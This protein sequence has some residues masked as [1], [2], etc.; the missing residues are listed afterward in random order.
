MNECDKLYDYAVGGTE[1]YREATANIQKVGEF[2]SEG[3]NMVQ[4]LKLTANK[5]IGSYN[6]KLINFPNGTTYSKNENIIKVI[7][8]KE[9][10]IGDIKGTVNIL[11]A[12]VK[13]CPAF[14]G[15]SYNE[16]WQDYVTA[17]DP[18]ENTSTQTTISLTTNNASI[19]IAKEDAETKQL[20]PNTTL[21]IEKDN[22]IIKT[23]VTDE[24]GE[25]KVD[26]LYAGKYK[27]TEIKANDN[28]ILPENA[29]KEVTIKYGETAIVRFS[30]MHKKG[31]LK[32]LKVDKDDNKLT[33]GGVEFDLLDKKGNVVKHLVTDVNGIAELKEINTGNYILRETSTKKEYNLALDEDVTIKWNETF[34]LQVENEKKK[35]QIK[36]V[37]VDSDNNEVKLEGVE[38]Q[39]IDRNNHV[40]ET[41]KTGKN[42][43]AMTSYLPIGEYK[44]KETSLG[45]N[46]E[47]ILNEEVKTVIIEENKIGLIQFENEHKKGN[48]KIYKI[49]LDNESISIPNVEFE[50]TDQD[51]YKY[52]AK[53]GEDGTTYIEN[54]RSGIA[55]IREVKTNTIY[56]L[57]NEI[58]SVEIKWNET[59]K[60]TIKNE[61]LKGQIEVYKIDSEN[62]EIKLEGVEFE[63]YNSNNELVETIK[64][65]KN[66]YAKTQPIPIGEY[67]VKETKTDEMHILKG[68]TIKINVTTDAVSRLDIT[69][70][71][72][73]GKIKIVKTSEKDNFVNGD[74]AG[75]PI[76][77]VQ[78]E[79][80]NS[81]NEL[82][83]IITTNEKRNSSYK[84]AG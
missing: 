23:V 10:I 4:T 51:G 31:N 47:Y 19:K 26:N 28:Y 61:K 6:V 84:E 13:T 55:T 34:E 37:K 15:Q 56:K 67:K 40:V 83:D 1:N 76:S 2:V 69:N 29:T 82:V 77:N 32:I 44:V 35:G 57:N 11:N 8:P 5:E 74:K 58:Y 36:I 73:K 38:F 53:T 16:T 12:E 66:G 48:L 65:D 70:D 71:R 50:I 39:I 60:I 9:N 27:V 72:I 7:I 46:L 41:I 64:T 54:I 17:A 22:K 14:Y 24:N 43:I 59:E 33:L 49:D 3:T 42:G 45:T 68:E 21:K 81:N 52:L 25:A 79:V 80:Y 62:K 63:I 75:S 30:N 18:Y 20:I 78:F